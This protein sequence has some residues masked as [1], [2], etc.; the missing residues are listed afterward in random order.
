MEHPEKRIRKQVHRY[1]ENGN[2]LCRDTRFFILKTIAD[3]GALS[4]LR[5]TFPVVRIYLDGVGQRPQSG[6]PEGSRQRGRAAVFSLD[7]AGPVPLGS[8]LG[9]YLRI[10]KAVLSDIQALPGGLVLPRVNA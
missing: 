1:I 3:G 5:G 2:P 6:C 10:P 8:E 7:S 4:L 9:A